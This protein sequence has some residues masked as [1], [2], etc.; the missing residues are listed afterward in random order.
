ML[1]D[2]EKIQEHFNITAG[3]K[4]YWHKGYRGTTGRYVHWKDEEYVA[5][6]IQ[7]DVKWFF[8]KDGRKIV[9]MTLI[10]EAIHAKGLRHD[11]KGRSMGYYSN[12]TK[13]TY[14]QPFYK[15]IFDD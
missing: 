14:S 10:H 2:W 9:R 1:E 4:I 15:E 11:V 6:T 8:N 3:L 12:Q 5:T 7:D 13:D